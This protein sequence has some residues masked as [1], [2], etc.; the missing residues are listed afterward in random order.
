MCFKYCFLSSGSTYAANPRLQSRAEKYVK[1]DVKPRSPAHSKMLHN[2]IADH[3][4]NSEKKDRL[5]PITKK[6][7]FENPCHGR[8]DDK[9][10]IGKSP[11]NKELPSTAKMIFECTVVNSCNEIFRDQS[12]LDEHIKS[13][14]EC[15]QCHLYFKNKRGIAVHQGMAHKSAS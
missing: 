13:N 8:Y 14:H 1:P 15:N 11:H 12:T 3:S 10:K 5:L 6:H 2:V 9:S 4:N 7:S